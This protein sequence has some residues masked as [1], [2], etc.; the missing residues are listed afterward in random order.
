M[1]DPRKRPF[2]I[3]VLLLTTLSLTSGFLFAIAPAPLAADGDA[4]RTLAT[5]PARL[6]VASAGLN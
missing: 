4:D 1:S 2:L 6:E 3:A 5:A